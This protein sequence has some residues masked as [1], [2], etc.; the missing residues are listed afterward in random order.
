MRDEIGRG[1][2]SRTIAASLLTRGQFKPSRRI[3]SRVGRA[4]PG[5]EWA[6]QWRIV[7][8]YPLIFF[9][10]FKARR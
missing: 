6:R 3:N 8:G 4:L 5:K 1:G 7:P 2:V 9:G 10:Q